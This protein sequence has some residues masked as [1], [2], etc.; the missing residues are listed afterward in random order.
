MGTGHWA[1]S[2]RSLV[3][4]RWSLEEGKR[5]GS[6]FNLN[7]QMSPSREGMDEEGRKQGVAGTNGNRRYFN[8]T[9]ARCCRRTSHCKSSVPEWEWE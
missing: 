3:A 5:G 9:S 6:Q 8:S 4:G 1:D 2:P 7:P